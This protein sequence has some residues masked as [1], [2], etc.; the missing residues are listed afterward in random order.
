MFCFFLGC[1]LVVCDRGADLA[2][3]VVAICVRGAVAWLCVCEVG[4]D[5]VGFAAVV[6]YVFL[7]VV[8]VLVG[9]ALW[10]SL[11]DVCDGVVSLYAVI[12]AGGFIANLWGYPCGGAIGGGAVVSSGVLNCVSAGGAVCVELLL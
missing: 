2:A 12:D 8:S 4:G 3:A 10:V 11:C 9:G 1:V 6:A 7:T 5:V